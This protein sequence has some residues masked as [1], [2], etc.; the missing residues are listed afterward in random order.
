[1]GHLVSLF[2][3]HTLRSPLGPREALINVDKASPGLFI[4]FKILAPLK[5]HEKKAHHKS[6]K[7]NATG[8][9]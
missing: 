7:L 5:T 8:T 4:G 1:M 9:I 3:T 6:Q 2:A